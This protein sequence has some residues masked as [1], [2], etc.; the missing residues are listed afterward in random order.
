MAN[1]VKIKESIRNDWLDRLNTLIGSGAYFRIYSGT[2]PTNPDTAKAGNTLLA[3]LALSASPF[4]AASAGAAA[5]NTITAD[6]SANATATATWASIENG[7][8]T[9]RYIDIEVGTSGADLNFNTVAFETGAN[10]SISGWT[11]TLAA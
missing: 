4:A 8:G 11:L 6:T 2:K 3:E 9:T 1:N 5:M 7:A 10:V